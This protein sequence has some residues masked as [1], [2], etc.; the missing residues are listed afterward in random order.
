MFVKPPIA[1]DFPIIKVGGDE[2][3]EIFDEFPHVDYQQS[4]EAADNY[5]A[6][7]IGGTAWF[8]SREDVQDKFDYLFIDEAGQVS[9]ANLV[10]MSA[11]T[12]NIVLMGDQMQLGQPIQGSHPG[13]SGQSILEYYLHGHATIPEHFGIFL[14]TSWRMHPGVCSFISEAVYEGRLKPEK[15]TK[16]RVIKLPANGGTDCTSGIRNPVRAGRARR[17]C[18][19]QR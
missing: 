10:G 7:L 3:D 12:K 13:E 2:D 17:Q 8:F 1:G 9:L 6:G 5:G 16:N 15:Q 14:G 19:G 18:P 4:G 11:S